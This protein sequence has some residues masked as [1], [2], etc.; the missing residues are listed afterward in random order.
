MAFRRIQAV[1]RASA[2]VRRRACSRRLGVPV[3]M[4]AQVLSS[5]PAPNSPFGRVI[6]GAEPMKAALDGNNCE[7]EFPTRQAQEGK[8]N[9]S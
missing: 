1:M 6:S 4:G 8:S 2:V 5:S 9:I 3:A 7:P